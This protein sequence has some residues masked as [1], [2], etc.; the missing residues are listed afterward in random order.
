MVVS[1]SLLRDWQPPNISARICQNP[2]KKK[3][4]RKKDVTF[5]LGYFSVYADPF[6][7][8]QSLLCSKA[9]RLSMSKPHAFEEDAHEG[10]FS[11]SSSLPFVGFWLNELR[12]T[13]RVAHWAA[14]PVVLPFR[15]AEEQGCTFCRT[16]RPCAI[17]G[18]P[19]LLHGD[20]HAPGQVTHGQC[21]S[22]VQ[23]DG[24][25]P[26]ELT[27]HTPRIAWLA[28]AEWAEAESDG[29]KLLFT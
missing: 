1:V 17:A 14:F 27:L 23:L 4:S 9:L 19:G 22:A 8:H 21:S 12:G 24:L 3:K 28:A 16:L 25:L 15:L 29:A 2:K 26:A 18:P 20:L 11:C 10:T 7:H 5:L 6:I 13:L